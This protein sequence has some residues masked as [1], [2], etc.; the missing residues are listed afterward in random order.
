MVVR[1]IRRTILSQF[2]FKETISVNLSPQRHYLLQIYVASLPIPQP[3]KYTRL[4]FHPMSS[5]SAIIS[6]KPKRST[7]VRVISTQEAKKHQRY[8]GQARA[9]NTLQTPFRMCLFWT[10]FWTLLCTTSYTAHA[11]ERQSPHKIMA[12]D[13][14]SRHFRS[15]QYA[16]VYPSKSVCLCIA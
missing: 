3:C 9:A 1:T 7:V 16:R 15:D 13:E 11:W 10:I 14:Q 5:T 4:E 12:S 6:G 8:F 2:A